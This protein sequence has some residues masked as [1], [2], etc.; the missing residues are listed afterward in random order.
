[1]CLFLD[2][3]DL[4]N[5]IDLSGM[6][7]D[8]H[9]LIQVCEKMATCPNL[10]GIHLNDFHLLDQRNEDLLREIVCIFKLE[11]HDLMCRGKQVMKNTRNDI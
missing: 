4:L 9:S 3:T 7:F 8:S 6:N 2:L 1:M 10:M 11:E 5:H